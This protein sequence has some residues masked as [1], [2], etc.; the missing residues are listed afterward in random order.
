MARPKNHVPTYLKHKASGRAYVKLRDGAGGYRYVYL[1]P[2]GTPESKERY[3]RE[4]AEHD[5]E[6]AGTA[7]DRGDN[8]A[9]AEVFLV[10]LKHAQSYY[11]RPDGSHTQE[12]A[13]YK[14]LSI[15]VNGLYSLAPA[16]EFGPQ[17]LKA[18]RQQMID[19]GLSR[20][21]I[22]QR[23]GRLKHVFKW[24]V[25]EELIPAA[26][27]QALCAVPGLQRGRTTAP[28]PKKVTPV[29]AS[30]VEATVPFLNRYV[31]GLIGFQQLT[32][33]RPGEACMVRRADIDTGGDV[34]L[35]R[36]ATHKGTW[37]DMDRIIAIGPQAQQLLKGF[38]T[39]NLD[40]YLFSPR[41]A[42]EELRADRAAGRKSPR[43]PSHQ[44]RYAAKRRKHPQRTPHEHYN[45]RTYYRAVARAVEKANAA[46]REGQ[47][48]KPIHGWH[49]NQLRH[50]FAT[51]VRK[52][53]GLEAAQVALGHSK[54]D[55]TQTYAERDLKL[56]V[57]VAK[58]VG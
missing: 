36:P 1:G 57:D 42:V 16:K 29:D 10:F 40:D 27:H 22:N 41:L 25:A 24:A 32:G 38:F 51:T 28:E 43:W 7:A 49:P 58:S 55:V 34:W 21:T 56:A 9:V 20:K 53:F 48:F 13:E 33:C 5:A 39:P 37:R 54:A 46:G 19:A 47:D 18:V 11:R 4:L 52:R 14:S 30:T 8:P 44:K 23:I 17:S 45:S 12:F 2:Y 6:A 31:R 3:R 50:S 15:I 26:V 35:Y